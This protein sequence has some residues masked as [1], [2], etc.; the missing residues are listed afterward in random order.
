M[1]RDDTVDEPEDDDDDARL[2][3]VRPSRRRRR[4]RVL[5]DDEAV[6]DEP[7]VLVEERFRDEVLINDEWES[8]ASVSSAM[9]VSK[10]T[11]VTE[12][13]AVK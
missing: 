5:D 10:S 1:S 6:E 4:S 7:L 9:S 2:A 12:F 8:E 13:L 3:L 11:S